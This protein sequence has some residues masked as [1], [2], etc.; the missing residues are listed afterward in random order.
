MYY[1]FPEHGV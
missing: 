1:F